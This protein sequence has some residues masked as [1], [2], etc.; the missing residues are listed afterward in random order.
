MSPFNFGPGNSTNQNVIKVIKEM[1]KHWKVINYKI[2]NKNLNYE[3]K[4]LKLN[5]SKSKQILR[6]KCILNF[7]ETIKLTTLWYKNFYS[8]NINNFVFSKSQ[9][10]QYEKKI[11]NKK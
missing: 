8:K 1:K 6:W 11:I 7:K 3:S 2:E 10:L 4:L 5:S 9:I